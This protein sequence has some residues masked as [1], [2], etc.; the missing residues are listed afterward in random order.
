MSETPEEQVEP[1]FSKSAARAHRKAG[2]D[3]IA[4]GHE[5]VDKA[6]FCTLG[7]PGMNTD[8]KRQLLALCGAELGEAIQKLSEAQIE[9]GKSLAEYNATAQ[10]ESGV[11]QMQQVNTVEDLLGPHQD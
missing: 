5:H 7:R 4:E 9:V 3:L 8:E 10:I 2:Q 11:S 1:E 6:I